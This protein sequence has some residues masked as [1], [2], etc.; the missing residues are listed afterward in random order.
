MDGFHV[1]SLLEGPLL[2]TIPPAHEE[3]VHHQPEPRRQLN[4]ILPSVGFPEQLLQLIAAHVLDVR[5]FFRIWVELHIANHEQQV[6][7][8]NSK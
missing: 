7:H 1:G 3:V 5:D 2:D 6:V 4:A 8:W